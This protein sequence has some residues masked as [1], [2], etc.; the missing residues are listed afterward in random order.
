M[1]ENTLMHAISFCKSKRRHLIDAKSEQ[2][3][4]SYAQI[5]KGLRGSGRRG[6]LERWLEEVAGR[7]Y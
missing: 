2:R 5:R 7:C 4:V 3:K 6:E 1:E